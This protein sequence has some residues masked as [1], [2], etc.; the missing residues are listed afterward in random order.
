MSL[1]QKDLPILEQHRLEQLKFH[2][3]FCGFL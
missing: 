3:F 2:G 1:K